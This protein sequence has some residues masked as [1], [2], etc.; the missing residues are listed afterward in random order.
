MLSR[1]FKLHLAAL[2]IAIHT[3]YI[4][5]CMD[6]AFNICK[7]LFLPINPNIKDRC[8]FLLIR[9][10]FTFYQF[11]LVFFKLWLSLLCALWTRFLGVSCFCKALRLAWLNLLIALLLEYGLLVLIEE[12]DGSILTCKRL[13]ISSDLFHIEIVKRLPS[14]CLFVKSEGKSWFTRN[15]SSS[16]LALL[17]VSL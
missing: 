15:P 12:Q 13:H 17:Y 3:H 5:L 8:F 4:L 16:K 7:L 9:L 14:V 11:P 2:L 6:Y 1:L 10:L